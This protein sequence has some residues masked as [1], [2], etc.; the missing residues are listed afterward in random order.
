MCSK[1]MRKYLKLYLMVSSPPSQTKSHA[2]FY[3]LYESVILQKMKTGDKSSKQFTPSPAPLNPQFSSYSS[4]NVL[5][6][7]L[8]W[9][10]T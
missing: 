10:V 9:Q 2:L 4:E 6:D 8:I 7:R 1:G 5:V 3:T